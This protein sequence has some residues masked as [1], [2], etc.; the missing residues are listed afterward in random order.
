[1]NSLAFDKIEPIGEQQRQRVTAATR[2]CVLHANELLDTSF[3]AIPV[4]FDL[5]G[6]AAGMYRVVRGQRV[7]RYNPYLF[8]KYFDENLTTTVPHEV[9]HYLTDAVYG[10]AN[11]KPHGNE[12]RRVMRMLGADAAVYCDFD[13]EGIP[14]RRYRRIRYTCRCRFYELPT[15]RHKR[16]QRKG[17]RYYCQVCRTELVLASPD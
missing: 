8:A 9:S 12:W 7:I 11:V 17:A 16:I 2:Q 15:I 13:L 5:T 3:D 10:Y 6:R 14:V 4:H 1:M